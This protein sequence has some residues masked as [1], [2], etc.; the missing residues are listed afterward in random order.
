MRKVKVNHID[1]I[2][3]ELERRIALNPRYS[4][5]AFAKNLGL[6]AGY[7][8][9]V[10]AG[11]RHLSIG[12]AQKIALAL[13]LTDAEAQFLF[14]S[15]AERDQIKKDDL[16]KKASQKKELDADTYAVISDMIH[17]LILEAT[18][19]EDFESD[20]RWMA[21]RFGLTVIEVEA[22]MA[23]LIRLGLLI[24]VE[25]TLRKSDR[26]LTIR[27][28]SKTSPALKSSQQQI[29]KSASKALFQDPIER[30][31][32]IGGT[33]TIDPVKLPLAKK[34]I[35]E[36]VDSLIEVLESGKRKEVFQIGV[37]LFSLEKNIA[38]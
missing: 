4:L 16:R 1:F 3:L 32:S 21:R 20:P 26:N 15:A 27:D 5:R 28:K 35:S 11:K 19:L 29:L 14:D 33:M 24:Q 17:Y 23:R 37:S 6:D 34:M 22:A 36:F 31:A 10:L 25:G 18:F 38:Q 2:N 12:A 8:S 13:N 7:L 30:R 9:N